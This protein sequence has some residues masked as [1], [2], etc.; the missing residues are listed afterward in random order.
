MNAKMLIKL[1]VTGGIIVLAGTRLRGQ[2]VLTAIALTLLFL[3]VATKVVSAV[4]VNRKKSR[5]CGGGSSPPLAPAMV[6]APRPPGAPPAV[7]CQPLD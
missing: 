4:F 5:P 6:P 1:T 7:Y 3:F 2:D